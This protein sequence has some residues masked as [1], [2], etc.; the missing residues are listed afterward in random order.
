VNQYRSPETPADVPPHIAKFF[1]N[2][3]PFVAPYTWQSNPLRNGSIWMFGMRDVIDHLTFRQTGEFLSGA[4]TLLRIRYTVDPDNPRSPTGGWIGTPEYDF[5]EVLVNKSYLAILSYRDVTY[6]RI[7]GKYYFHRGSFSWA[8]TSDFYEFPKLLNTFLYVTEVTTDPDEMRRVRKG[9]RLR[10]KEAM[11]DL[12]IKYDPD[13]W[14]GE[15]RLLQLPADET[16]RLQLSTI[17]EVK[18][19]VDTVG[20]DSSK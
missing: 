4:D 11:S 19:P 9:K 5:A 13:Y 14:R 17:M 12:R 2:Q 20:R 18:L 16:V 1:G 15:E 8:L 7:D 3:Y 10:G 6:R